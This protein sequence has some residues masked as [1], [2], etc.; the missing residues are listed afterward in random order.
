MVADE[1]RRQADEFIDLVHL[2]N[3][4]GRDPIERTAERPQKLPDRKPA[5]ASSGN[6]DHDLVDD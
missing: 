2:V 6:Y 5:T 4:I 1:L 3:K